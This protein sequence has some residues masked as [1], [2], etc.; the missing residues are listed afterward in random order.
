MKTK[1]FYPNKIFLLSFIFISVFSYITPARNLSNNPESVVYDSV[2]HRYLVSNVGSGNI[3]QINSDGSTSNFSTVLA[4]TLGMVIVGDTL[5]VADITGVVGFNLAT[6][7]RIRTIPIPGMNVLNDITTD[8]VGFLYVTDSGNGKIYKVII[9]DGTSQTIASGIYW[10]NGILYDEFSHRLLFCVFGSNVSIREIDLTNYSVSTIITTNFTDLD[11]LTI[12]NE[13]KIYVS[14]WGSNKVYRYDNAFSSQPQVISSG[15][16]GPADIFFDKINNV[17]VVP[18][19]NSNVIEFIDIPTNLSQ[20]N[21][22][23]IPQDFILYQNYPNPFNPTTKISYQIP[24]PSFVTLKVYDVL[25][26]EISTLVNEEKSAGIYEFNFDGTQL[27]SGI[28]F[29][30]LQAVNYT[31]SIKMLLVK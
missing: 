18:D 21:A 12:D 20:D 3:V 27:S 25:G 28:Y 1:I 24:A 11:G 22:K 19:F 5:Y 14:S 16:N 7:N 23:V 8:G 15:H 17:L 30:R 13:N 6:G 2:M 4:R 10:P 26:N 31:Q 9:E 29:C